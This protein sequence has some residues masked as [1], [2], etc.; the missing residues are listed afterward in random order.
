MK[1]APER[2]EPR[3]RSA[4]MAALMPNAAYARL[5]K[6]MSGIFLLAGI[7]ALSERVWVL[8][9]DLHARHTW[10]VADGQIVSAK[11]QDDSEMPGRLRGHTRYWI[12]YEVRFAL[13]PERCRTG[14]IYEGPSESMPCHGI[15]QTR[16][17]QSTAEVFQ[18]FLHG[19]HVNEPVKVLWNPEATASTDVKIA[20]E[21]IWV[22]Y[23]FGRLI[24]SL[25]WVLGFGTV[26]LFSRRE[27]LYPARRDEDE[28]QGQQ[29][30]VR[31]RP[32][33]NDQLTDLDLH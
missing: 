28:G 11:Q 14:I 27:L 21:S 17:T 23:N 16:S 13:P 6:F 5:W 3:G 1:V 12:E 15:V 8:A 9:S 7:L 18:W 10:P 22:R 20:E 24:F 19:F 4:L 33:S 26:Y 29:A 25:L 30:Y 32:D 31:D 2:A